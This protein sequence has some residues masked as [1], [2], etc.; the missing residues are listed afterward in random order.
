MGTAQ[1]ANRT[2]LFPILPSA[3]YHRL[4]HSPAYFDQPLLQ[5]QNIKFTEIEDQV[6]AHWEKSSSLEK[7]I[8][9]LKSSFSRLETMMQNSVSK[10]QS[11]PASEAKVTEGEKQEAM[12]SLKE[13][14]DNLK[15]SL[16]GEIKGREADKRTYSVGFSNQGMAFKRLEEKNI[17]VEKEIVELKARIDEMTSTM[18]GMA[19]VIANAEL[20]H[21]SHQPKETNQSSEVRITDV[22]MITVSKGGLYII[23]I[24]LIAVLIGLNL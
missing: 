11:R 12:T 18:V 8:L 21:E 5:H 20:N 9:G 14:V 16:D 4:P 1:S 23:L 13:K 6:Q 10:L 22:G 15:R 17:E 19:A 7:E 24:F 3:R 2:R